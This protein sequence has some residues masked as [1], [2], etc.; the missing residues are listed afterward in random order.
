MQPYF[1]P[2]IGYFQLIDAVD[3][4]IVYDDIKYTKKGWINRN[5]MLV[6]GEA[7]VFSLP[8][9]HAPDASDIRA[10]AIASVY[11]PQ[12][13]LNRFRGAYARAPELHV[14][15]PLLE[16]VLFQP[17]RNLFA[18]LWG[19]LALTCAHL[20]VRTAMQR[21]SDIIAGSD[22]RHEE[23]VLATCRAAGATTYINAIGGTELYSRERF[24][25]QG[26]AL[27]FVQT[28]A[29]TY[30]QYDD[31]FVAWLSIVDVLMFNPRDTVRAWIGSAYELV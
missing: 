10:R 1:L 13:L 2:Y 25:D 20:G 26:V 14:T 8:L 27:R 17:E 16:Q 21:S 12:K 28:R 30:R 29:I 7:A 15:L 24:A 18:F 23:R 4:F 11:D 31:P 9:E 22:L 6:N 3:L 5:R 19:A